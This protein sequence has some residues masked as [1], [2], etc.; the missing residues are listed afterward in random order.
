MRVGKGFPISHGLV[1]RF[2]LTGGGI[3][4]ILVRRLGRVT[5]ARMARVCSSVRELPARAVELWAYSISN[6]RC[7]WRIFSKGME[8]FACSNCS[9][10][11]FSLS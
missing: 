6:S 7:F 1:G 2:I 3:F 4:C 10:F 9:F 5:A 8:G 11:C